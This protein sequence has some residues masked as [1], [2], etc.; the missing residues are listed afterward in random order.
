MTIRC[1]GLYKGLNK[2]THPSSVR[3]HDIKV[4]NNPVRTLHQEYPSLKDTPKIEKQTNVVYKIGC[5]DC[6]WSRI[7]ETGRCFETQKK[8][9][10][11]NVKRN[12]AGSNM[13]KHSWTM[14][15]GAVKMDKS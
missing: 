14:D 9:Y 15:H 12:T 5:K 4:L 6:S 10:I 8:E 3:K 1:S 11:R 7:G 2:T 13:A